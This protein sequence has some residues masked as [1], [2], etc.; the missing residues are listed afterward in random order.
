M[1]T[2]SATQR[3]RRKVFVH[4]VSAD[5]I[6]GGELRAWRGLFVF[7]DAAAVLGAFAGALVLHDPSGAM[8]K[9]LLHTHPPLVWAVAPTLA[10]LWLMVF[11]ACGLYGLRRGRL[12]EIGAIMRGCSIAA[13]LT[14]LA[15]FLAHLD[16]SRVTFTV[17]YLL[18]MPTVIGERAIARTLLGRFYSN[19]RNAIPLLIVGY[20]ELARHLCDQI[21]DQMTPY[22]V[23]GFVDDAPAGR[24][25][26]G[27]PVLVGLDRIKEIAEVCP[28][29]EAA[30]V[31]PWTSGEK[32]LE[33]VRRCEDGRA[34]Y[35]LLPPWISRRPSGGLRIELFGDMPLIS[36]QSSNIR[37]VNLALKRLFDICAGVLLLIATSP[38]LAIASLCVR[39]FDG[40]PIFYRQIRLGRWGRP[41]ECLK[42]RTMRREAHD[43]VHRD[44]VKRWIRD[45]ESAGNGNGTFKISDDGRVTRLGRILRRFS[46]DELPQLINV[47][48]GDMSLVG[49]R[50]A[51]PYEVELYEPEHLRRL[52][53]P[54]GI[55]GLWQVSG[56]NRLSFDEMVELDVHYMCNWSLGADLKILARTLSAALGGDGL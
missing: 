28:G 42:L 34:R 29:L 11:H 33:V 35:W 4:A 50:P 1:S 5:P 48:R 54:P 52:E 18:S 31:S 53:T 46:I 16:A 51:L 55:T 47:I 40:R 12:K 21:L 13:L 38:V 9:R 3:V 20:N 36:P 24:Q 17:A 25:Y 30:V 49:P 44:Y 2:A 43:G 22:D 19:P 26:R 27:R 7:S 14:V 6:F 8:S 37:G 56:R 39:V 15:A 45:G 41:F 32:L 10:I 23:V